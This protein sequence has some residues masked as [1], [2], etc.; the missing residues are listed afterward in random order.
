[1]I[2]L[3]HHLHDDFGFRLAEVFFLIRVDGDVL[4][5]CVGGIAIGE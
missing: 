4:Q 1:M 3:L 5:F 2:H